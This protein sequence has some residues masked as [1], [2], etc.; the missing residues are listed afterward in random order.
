MVHLLNF[1]IKTKLILTIFI[2]LPLPLLRHLESH[3]GTF[4]PSKPPLWPTTGSSW[5][6][7][8]PLLGALGA[9]RPHLYL[10]LNLSF[11]TLTP[12]RAVWAPLW[13][14]MGSFWV[15]LGPYRGYPLLAAFWAPRPLPGSNFELPRRHFGG[16]EAKL[17]AQTFKASSSKFKSLKA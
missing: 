14:T 13:P 6:A 1:A 16:S 8:G 17:Q 2:S 10:H 4:W 11:L 5:A 12:C 15:L 9:P 3:L 7:P